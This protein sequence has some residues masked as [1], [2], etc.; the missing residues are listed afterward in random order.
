MI[1][2]ALL[3]SCIDFI[4]PPRETT[5][6][7]RN[8]TMDMASHYYRHIV[9]DGV[10]II[11]TYTNNDIRA[12]IHEAKFHRNTKAFVILHSLFETFLREKIDKIDIIIPIPLSRARMR[13]RGYNQV[14]EIL[15]AGKS[16]VQIPIE[17]KILIRTRDTRP[18]T[19]LTR[20]K[21]LV[22]LH[23]AFGVVQGEKITGKHILLV[24]DVMTTGTTLKTAKASLLPYNPASITCIAL[25]H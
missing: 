15:H 16:H 1:M 10:H 24:D 2:S 3:T 18:Q 6:R 9:T 17:T 25:A 19:E 22:N 5:L 20:E 12:L 21:R 4:F 8:V 11:C 14:Y 13:A 7:V 23:D